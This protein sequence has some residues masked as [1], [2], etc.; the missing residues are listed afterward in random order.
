MQS[1]LSSVTA[2][3]P[4]KLNLFLHVVGR[5]DDGYHLLDSL[6]V[7]AAVGDRVTATE[8]ES[9]G[10]AI[11]GPFAAGLAAG[12]DNLVRRAAR[13]L[14]EAAGVAPRAALR[15]DKR[16][17]VASGI[18]GGSADAA[19]ALKALQVL[20]GTRVEGPALRDLALGL[21]ADVPVCLAG[22]P[23]FMGGIGDD[24]AVAPALPEAWVA[25]V[26]PG[27]ALSTPAVFKARCGDFSAPGRFTGAP[28]SVADLADL[29]RTRRNDLEAPARALAPAVGAA[30]DA[31]AARP[32]CL[33]ARMSGSGATC[34]GLFATEAAA[35]AAAEVIGRA[36]TGWWVTAAR[37]M[38][39]R[40][41]FDG[42]AA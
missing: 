32:G 22:R 18:G 23:S 35:R 38:G 31:L 13:R 6:V 17:P 8:S 1:P 28:A 42:A 19:A 26:N 34:L 2:G 10:L 20:W 36:E 3:A 11:D 14:A 30:L 41:S 7:F 37:L 5:R 29:L 24:L 21:G 15:L 27:V 4:A 12:D 9:L 40:D 16:L 39:P 25:L 33:I